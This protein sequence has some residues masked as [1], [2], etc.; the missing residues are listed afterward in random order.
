MAAV[1]TE[2]SS[3]IFE[4]NGKASEDYVL[5]TS[6]TI[7]E[8]FDSLFRFGAIANLL[9]IIFL[10][11]R[12]PA[13]SPQSFFMV[14]APTSTICFL[15][16]A[17]FDEDALFGP[18][19]NIL[20]FSA[21]L[22]FI[23]IWFLCVSIL[24]DDFDFG[25]LYKVIYFLYIVRAI[26]FVGQFVSYELISMVSIPAMTILTSYLL[27]INIKGIRGDLIYKRIQFRLFLAFIILILYVG[28]M[29]ERLFFSRTQYIDNI[30]ILESLSAFLTSSLFI[31][32]L[33]SEKIKALLKSQA[34]PD[35]A[36]PEAEDARSR[37]P[38][39]L[40][41]ADQHNL[42]VLKK[43]MQAGLYREQ[44]L[45]VARLAEEVGVPEHRLR[46]LINTYMGYRNIAEFLNEYR[47]AEAKTRL[48]DMHQRHIPV[49]TIAME[50]GYIS[51]RPF[52]RAFKALTAQTPSEYREHHLCNDG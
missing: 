40:A 13:G 34:G 16:V 33:A 30:S 52:N 24:K 23:H 26:I 28:I 50:A 36:K 25:Y 46:K 32:Y 49:L 29:V 43:K 12:H 38:R 35:L 42:A 15:I 2:F 18:I 11:V 48:A 27:Y 37:E 5:A 21:R 9:W 7:L 14:A 22:T 1:F 4:L 45:T 8:F 20:Q 47:I 6:L 31:Y 51:L 3:L 10:S 41:A 39:P 19:G 44:G 17:A